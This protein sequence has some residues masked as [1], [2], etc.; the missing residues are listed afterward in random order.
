MDETQKPTIIDK[1]SITNE[2]VV[3]AVSDPFTYRFLVFDKKDSQGLWYH[4]TDTIYATADIRPIGT[5]KEGFPRTEVPQDAIDYHVLLTIPL[6]ELLESDTAKEAMSA[7]SVDTPNLVAVLQKEMRRETF[8]LKL[9]R[10]GLET[11]NQII[12]NIEALGF[13]F[14]EEKEDRK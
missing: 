3:V 12:E 2:R 8:R 4:E 13:I 14:P 9:Q 6:L 7:M 10:V 11:G 5:L 1:I